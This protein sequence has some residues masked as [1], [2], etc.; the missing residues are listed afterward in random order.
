MNEFVASEVA[1]CP[2]VEDC[3]KALSEFFT[4]R[5][6]AA[7]P[8][9]TPPPGNWPLGFIVA[10]YDEAGVG[11]VY[12]VTILGPKLFERQFG[13]DQAGSLWRGQRDVVSRLIKGRDVDALDASGVVFDSTGQDV[14]AK[15]EYILIPPLTLTDAA[16][17]ASF[18][19]RTTI[20]MQRFSDGTALQPG[21]IPGCGGEIQMLAATQSGTRW[22]Q[23]TDGPARRR[24][25]S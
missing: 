17:F 21:L 9:F 12:E 15:L 22:L 25:R 23:R 13:T 14:L 4:A 1:K 16:D 2:A 5:F 20:Q 7:F 6:N 11:H 3:A 19:V 18:L 8:G 10:G 24:R